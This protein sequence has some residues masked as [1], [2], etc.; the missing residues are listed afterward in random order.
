MGKAIKLDCFTLAEDKA[1]VPTA[2]IKSSPQQALPSAPVD[3]LR[4]E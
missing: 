3:D 2:V 4:Y 1:E